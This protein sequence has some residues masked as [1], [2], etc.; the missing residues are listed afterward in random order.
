MDH[1]FPKREIPKLRGFD[2]LTED[3]KRLILSDPKNM[4]PLTAST[5]CS[6]GCRVN[7]TDNPWE[8]Y[9]G[10][11]LPD[12]YKQWLEDEQAKSMRY[13]EKRIDEFL[14]GN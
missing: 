2:R 11:P 1:I 14:L 9:K 13:L 3:Q 8:T 4:Q 7:G 12:S 10:N 5:N 6:K